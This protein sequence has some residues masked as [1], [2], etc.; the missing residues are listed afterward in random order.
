MRHPKKM[1]AARDAG[2]LTDPQASASREAEAGRCFS[3]KPRPKLRKSAIS[4]ASRARCLKPALHDP[5]WTDLSGPARSMQ[6]GAYPPLVGPDCTPAMGIAFGRSHPMPRD[7]RLADRDRAASAVAARV[8][9]LHPVATTAPDPHLRTP[10]EAPL[11]DRGTR[12]IRQVFRAGIT[13]FRELI[14]GPAGVARMSVA[15]SGIMR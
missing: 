13:F 5:R 14:P 7:P 9:V 10:P 3:M 12:I 11:V 8:C 6:A 2:V 4:P 15:I 1:R